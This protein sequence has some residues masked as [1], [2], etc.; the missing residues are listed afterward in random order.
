MF[1]ANAMPLENCREASGRSEHI[2]SGATNFV[3]EPGLLYAWLFACRE[4]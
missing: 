3:L 1:L 2:A 4:G